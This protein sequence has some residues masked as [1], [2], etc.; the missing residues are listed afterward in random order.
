M[1]NSSNAAQT[2]APGSGLS[3]GNWNSWGPLTNSGASAGSSEYCRFNF[4]SII[5]LP[6]NLPTYLPNKFVRSN[7]DIVEV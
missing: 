7:T 4:F 1:Y 3:G 5:L 6:N 2:A